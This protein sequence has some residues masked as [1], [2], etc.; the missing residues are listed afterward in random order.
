MTTI[1][2]VDQSASQ[3]NRKNKIGY[4]IFKDGEL[5]NFGELEAHPP[6]F[7]E[8]RDWLRNRILLT[9]KFDASDDKDDVCVAVETVY[10]GLNPKVFAGLLTVKEHLHA[11][12]S[13]MGCR[14][15][16]ISPIESANVV[17]AKYSK[18]GRKEAV[19]KM[20]SLMFGLKDL[21]E[22]EADAI[23]IGVAADARLRIEKF[24][25]LTATVE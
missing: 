8:N 1:I 17:G 21:S 13:D 7:K 14:Y 19:M 12:A 10:L 9:G 11:V 25:T 23:A 5:S 18:G 2:A 24:Q 4:A 15:M 3:S 20:V 16:E 22:H 6:H